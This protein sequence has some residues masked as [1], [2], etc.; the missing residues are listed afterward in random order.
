MQF[1][2]ASR[3]AFRGQAGNS[4]PLRGC[5]QK[6]IDINKNDTPYSNENGNRKESQEMNGDVSIRD[7][8]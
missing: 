8:R 3:K 6:I 1:Q 5:Q 2:V 4:I 7:L